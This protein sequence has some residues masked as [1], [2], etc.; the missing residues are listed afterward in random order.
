MDSGVRLDDYSESSNLRLLL[1]KLEVELAS[2]KRKKTDGKYG[3]Q[4]RAL[5]LLATSLLM[6]CG[7]SS[8]TVLVNFAAM[9]GIRCDEKTAQRCIKSAKAAL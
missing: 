7:L 6:K 4:R 3:D 8:P 2:T 9:T 5:K 1:K